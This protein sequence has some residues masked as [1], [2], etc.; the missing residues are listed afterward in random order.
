MTTLKLP[1]GTITRVIKNINR[2]RTPKQAIMAANCKNY[3]Y[4]E[5]VAE[6]PIGKGQ[7]VEV[8]LI[9]FNK[10]LSVDDLE[11]EVDKA[12][13]VFVDPV[14]LSALNEQDRVI[15]DSLPNATQWR[16]KNGKVCRMTFGRSVIGREVCVNQLECVWA[17]YW[18]FGCVPK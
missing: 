13:F 16:D 4:D 1:E 18:H 10:Q 2:T 6:M 3:L 9:P 14:T 17:D 11:K 12:G 8:Y 15:T 5:V 7:E